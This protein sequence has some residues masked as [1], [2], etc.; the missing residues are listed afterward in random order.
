MSRS[1]ED[2]ARLKE[3]CPGW[4]KW[5]SSPSFFKGGGHSSLGWFAYI[6]GENPVISDPNTNHVRKA[7]ENLEFLAVQDLFISDTAEYA[8]VVL[9]GASFAE[10]DGTF[11]NTERRCERIRKAMDCVG[12]SKADWEIIKKLIHLLFHL[13]AFFPLLMQA[14]HQANLE[15]QSLL[16]LQLQ[17]LKMN[18]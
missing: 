16:Q 8:D 5:R 2:L 9:A 17:F 14:L 6:M 18:L 15:R 10:K 11:T 1:D 3:R 13:E 4:E 7:L 12:N